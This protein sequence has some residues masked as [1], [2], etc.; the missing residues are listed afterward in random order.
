M[1][2]STLDHFSQLTLKEILK[3]KKS[4]NIKTSSLLKKTTLIRIQHLL[5][6]TNHNQ[7]SMQQADTSEKA[8]VG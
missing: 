4:P 8:W 5:L 1:I 7:A 6:I 3:M 2:S